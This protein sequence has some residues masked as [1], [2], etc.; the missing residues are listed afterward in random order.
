[1]ARPRKDPELHQQEGTYRSD[2]HG[3]T[4]LDDIEPLMTPEHLGADGQA[5]WNSIVSKLQQSGYA[6]GMDAAGLELLCETEDLYKLA[7][8]R[9][10]SEPPVSFTEKGETVSAAWKIRNTL[11]A[12]KLS[13]AR[14][15]GLTINSRA[16]LRPVAVKDENEKQAEAML[17]LGG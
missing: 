6:T 14:Q 12:M 13:I 16:N 5:L 4:L 10:L 7:H 17:G 15:Y 2:R 8:R 11:A 9:A 1:M 3:T